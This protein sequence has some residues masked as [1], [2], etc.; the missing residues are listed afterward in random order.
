[1]TLD[2]PCGAMAPTTQ[3]A[4]ASAAQ[5]RRFALLLIVVRLAWMLL[6]ILT[7]GL[8]L[9]SL[10]LLLAA[11]ADR[12]AIGVGYYWNADSEFVLIATHGGPAANAG[13]HTDDVLVAIDGRRV[14]AGV[15]AA[16]VL[17]KLTGPIGSPVRVTTRAVDGTIR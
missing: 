6:V 12:G 11:P 5:S 3:L 15:P 7:V 9:V 2:P 10:P 4:L 13:I 16:N 14:G 1:M 17:K 8:L